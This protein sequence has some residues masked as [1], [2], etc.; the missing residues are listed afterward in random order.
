M[1]LSMTRGELYQLFKAEIFQELR[2]GKD[3]LDYWAAQQAEN[4]ITEQ[5]KFTDLSSQPGFQDRVLLGVALRLKD[6]GVFIN[7]EEQRADTVGEVIDNF[8]KNA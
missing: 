4:R 3:D 6:R 8:L 1:S 5:A 2:T 7:F